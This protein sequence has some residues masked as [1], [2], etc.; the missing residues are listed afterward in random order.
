MLHHD[1]LW[2]CCAQLLSDFAPYG[3]RSRDRGG[4]DCSCGCRF[5][6]SL[7]GAAGMDWGVCAN[8]GS[9]RKGLLTFEHQGCFEFALEEGEEE[10]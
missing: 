2:K 1:D 8:P 10:R 6:A 9:P 7:E 3:N 5:Y 4:P